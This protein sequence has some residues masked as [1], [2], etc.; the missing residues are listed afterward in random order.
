MAYGAKKVVIPPEFI[1]TSDKVVRAIH[2]FKG[3]RWFSNNWLPAGKIESTVSGTGSISW[4]TPSLDL[5]TGTT[6][7]SY[8]KVMK[9]LYKE[10]AGATIQTWDKVRRFRVNL[11]FWTASDEIAHIVMGEIQAPSQLA[12]TYRHI[13]FKLDNNNLYAS[14]G[15]GSVETE[16]LVK[17]IAAYSK[18]ELEAILTPGKDCKFYVDRELVATITSNLPSGTTDA[19]DLFQASIYNKTAVNKTMYIREVSV[20]QEE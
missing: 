11:R 12:N 3:I 4:A 2:G 8:A 18:T 20:L 9:R 13:G 10:G 5:A 7:L 19:E 16:I 6:A 15:N 14:V 1:L 17:T